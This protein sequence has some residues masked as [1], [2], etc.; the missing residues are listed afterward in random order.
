M[1]A[2]LIEDEVMTWT[3]AYVY[4]I[5]LLEETTEAMHFVVIFSK[6]TE[7]QP[8]PDVVVRVYFRITNFTQP[9]LTYVIENERLKHNIE[10]S[11]FKEE[12]LD[13]VV[14]QKKHIV[15]EMDAVPGT[16][17]LLQQTAK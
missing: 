4:S 3:S 8:I 12:W 1:G 14:A 16:A 7:K 5:Q 17:L 2:M 11:I 15:A 6:P 9:I 10:T 13:R